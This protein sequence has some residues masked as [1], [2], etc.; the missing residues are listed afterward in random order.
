MKSWG[1]EPTCDRSSQ[2]VRARC[3]GL[4]TEYVGQS[5]KATKEILVGQGVEGRL[6]HVRRGP[7]TETMRS[8]RLRCK[9]FEFEIVKY[10]IIARFFGRHLEE[11]E[12]S[13]GAHNQ[14]AIG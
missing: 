12:A 5:T 4:S 8:Q 9:I 10:P 13:V 1:F 3:L 14:T 6:V 2:A 7:D 11:E